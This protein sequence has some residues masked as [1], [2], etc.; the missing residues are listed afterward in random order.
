MTRV[1]HPIAAAT[2]AAAVPSWAWAQG[3]APDPDRYWYGPQMM[4]GG[5]YGMI[6]GPIFMILVLVAV[7]AT[8]VLIVRWAGGPW[9]PPALPHHAPGRQPLDILKER[10]ARGEI[11]KAEFDERRR[12][13]GE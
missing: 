12:V 7:I 4:W 6:F 5:G 3:G 2:A 9:Q 1:F 13:L 8:V 11:D 10:F